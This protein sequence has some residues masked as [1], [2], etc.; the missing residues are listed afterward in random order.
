MIEWWTDLSPEARGLYGTL[1][2][3]FGASTVAFVVWATKELRNRASRRERQLVVAR[4]A[5][6]LDDSGCYCIDISVR[7]T[8]AIDAIIVGGRVDVESKCSLAVASHACSALVPSAEYDLVMEPDDDQR[9]YSVALSQLIPAS[10]V[11]KFRVRLE[12]S[13]NNW[14]CVFSIALH[15]NEAGREV[16]TNRIAV[17]FEDQ[18]DLWNVPETLSADLRIDLERAAILTATATNLLNKLR[19]PKPAS[20]Q[21]HASLPF[22]F[23]VDPFN[24][25]FGTAGGAVL[26]FHY[27]F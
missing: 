5:V 18:F 22:E 27:F 25:R 7:N 26:G 24:F 12:S 16:S 6:T 10:G 3:A 15:V 23:D 9:S 21:T 14:V 4:E 20:P 2:G 13:H 17:F 19:E 11:D 8:S 1:I